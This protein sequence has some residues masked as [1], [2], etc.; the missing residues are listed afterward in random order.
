MQEMIESAMVIAKFVIL[1]LLLGSIL[2]ITRG[3]RKYKQF[4]DT[5][6]E[7]AKEYRARVNVGLAFFAVFAILLV[8]I[9]L[10]VPHRF[11]L[12]A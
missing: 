8:L 3:N 9:Q 5:D 7:K 4:K 6:A 11:L 12:G 1:A 10:E 2:M